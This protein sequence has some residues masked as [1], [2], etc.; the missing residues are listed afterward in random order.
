MINILT[1]RL[2]SSEGKV[3]ICGFD[4]GK[5]QKK[6]REIVSMCPQ[7]D[8]CWSDLTVYEHIELFA[9]IREIN[10]DIMNSYVLQKIAEV[11]LGDRASYRVKYLSGGMKRRLSIA[12]ATVGDPSVVFLDEPTTGLDPVTQAEIMKLINV[13]F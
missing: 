6:I 4:L 10:E 11:G 2:S 8:I 7:F 1:S 3:E 5:D 12:I 9:R 13:I